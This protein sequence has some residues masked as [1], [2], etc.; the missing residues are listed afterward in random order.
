VLLRSLRSCRSSATV[1]DFLRRLVE[2]EVENAG[3]RG[4]RRSCPRD[5]WP[6]SRSPSRWS[7]PRT[8]KF[9]VGQLLGLNLDR[10]PSRWRLRRL[11]GG[12]V[13]ASPA[14]RTV[15]TGRGH[16]LTLA[17]AWPSRP[18]PRCPTP[19]FASL[20][21]PLLPAPRRRRCTGR[22]P[23]PQA[24]M[25]PPTPQAVIGYPVGCSPWTILRQ[26]ALIA[27]T[28]YGAAVPQPTPGPARPSSSRAFLVRGPVAAPAVRETVRGGQIAD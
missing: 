21:P 8:G 20:K 16:W 28:P 25:A 4:V 14:T 1:R 19:A 2:H 18:P 27:A 12:L 17:F 26:P 7:S 24:L 23:V 6:R 13:D 11:D 3:L 22:C 15:S 10:G 9:V 5:C